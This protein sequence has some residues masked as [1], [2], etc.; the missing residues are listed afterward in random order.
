MLKI[1]LSIIFDW[2]FAS[3]LAELLCSL[4]IRLRVRGTMHVSPRSRSSAY[5]LSKRGRVHQSGSMA[6]TFWELSSLLREFISSSFSLRTET[7]DS[8]KTYVC[9]INEFVELILSTIKS[10]V[11]ER[12]KNC[13]RQ[14]T[15]KTLWITSIKKH[16]LSTIF[17]RGYEAA[18]GYI[19]I[20]K[21]AWFANLDNSTSATT[22]TYQH[23]SPGVCGKWTKRS[24]VS[25]WLFGPCP[26][27][28]KTE[29]R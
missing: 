5:L 16:F 1:F 21:E 28:R 27:F 10:S 9:K 20:G 25:R 13:E 3:F 29:T 15:V 26:R 24:W 17:F 4:G 22:P 7:S 2:D 11:V 18:N 19:G 6:E 8:V 12:S 14:R 23:P